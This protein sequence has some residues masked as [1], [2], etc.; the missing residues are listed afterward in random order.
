MKVPK[1][2]DD[3]DYDL[4][5]ENGSYFMRIKR[6]GEQC[7]INLDTMRLLRN[8]EK[9]LRREKED[10]LVPVKQGHKET[11]RKIKISLLSLDYL[12]S[13]SSQGE[14]ALRYETDFNEGLATSIKEE[15]FRLQLTKRQLL[16]YE[17]CL[18]QGM[19]YEEFSELYGI[20]VDCI[21][22][23]VRWVRKK[24]RKFF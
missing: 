23:T 15:G 16:V 19:P 5:T 18:L 21:R 13:N 7:E 17:K 1:T 6:T 8:E 24:A 3:F 14:S 4:W 12:D 10:I 9:R 20:S 11:D 22:S 2:P